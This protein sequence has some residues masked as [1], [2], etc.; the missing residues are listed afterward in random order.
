MIA[1]VSLVATVALA[2]SSADAQTPAQN[3]YVGMWK[4]VAADKILPDGK[5]VADYGAVP[6]GLAIFTAD[7]HFMIDVFRDVRTKFAGKNREKGTFEEYKDAQLTSSCS[8]GTYSFDAATG[9]VTLHIDRSTF[10]NNDDTTQ[11]RDYELKGDTLSWRVSPR[12]DGSIPV[13][14]VRRIVVEGKRD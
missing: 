14:V 4:L 11:I 9:K 6:H 1:I 3:P 7:G 12:S 10:P 2:I 13:T 8:F 5:R